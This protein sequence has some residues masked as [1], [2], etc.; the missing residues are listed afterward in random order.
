MN[1]AYLRVDPQLVFDALTGGL[2]KAE[3]VTCSIGQDGLLCFALRGDDALPKGELVAQFS[4]VQPVIAVKSAPDGR[5][6][7]IVF[8]G[9]K[10]KD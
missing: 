4:T 10:T 2:V 3:V 9:L 5:V 6:S 8:D 1:R 7:A